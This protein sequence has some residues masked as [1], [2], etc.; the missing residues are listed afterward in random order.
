M[1]ILIRVHAVS[2]SVLSEDLRF[3][4][5]VMSFE[6]EAG[7]N[8]VGRSVILRGWFYFSSVSTRDLLFIMHDELS[9]LLEPEKPRGSILWVLLIAI[10]QSTPR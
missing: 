5:L 7:V 10:N 9:I 4:L 1:G 3:C 2:I 8:R 6:V